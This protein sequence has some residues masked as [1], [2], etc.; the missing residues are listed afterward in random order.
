MITDGSARVPRTRL[1][2][3][4]PSLG[5]SSFSHSQMH[6]L[7]SANEKY[8]FEILKSA[9]KTEMLHFLMDGFRVDESLNRASKITCEEI[10]KCLNGALDRALKAECSIL[11]RS[12]ESHEIVGCMLSSVWRRDESLS[13]PEGE[14]KDFEFRSVR[15]EVAMVGEI[16][17]EL[18][19]SF[20]SLRPDHDVVLHFEISSVSKKHR[21][22]G[23]A[24][25]FMNW[26]ESKEL[27]KSL[28]ATGI[29][30]EA[31]SL[32]NQVLLSKRNY[33]TIAT[34]FLDTKVDSETGNPVLTCDDGTDRVCL[35]FKEI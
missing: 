26:T 20:W 22:Q 15:K 32:A 18:H 5:S 2:A 29:V 27:L 19:E 28:E 24:S 4:F 9:Q 30:T 6:N 1:G 8:Y 34:T 21:R 33:K 25:K 3:A 13:T 11:A 14:D 7:P 35:M 31:S 17:N 16:L 10:E 23:L 12:Q